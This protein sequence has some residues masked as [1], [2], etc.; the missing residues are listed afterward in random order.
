M[1]SDQILLSFI[2]IQCVH[3][4]C[5]FNTKFNVG[6]TLLMLCRFTKVFSDTILTQPYESLYVKS[7]TF[8][9][10]KIVSFRG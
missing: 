9:P 10:S 5:Y 2:R 7:A 1:T 3:T 6:S 8:D 4:L